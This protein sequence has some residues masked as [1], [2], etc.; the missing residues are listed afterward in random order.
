MQTRSRTKAVVAALVLTTITG[1]ASAKWADQSGSLPGLTSGTTIGL[2]A[3]L[4]GGGV[5]A[6]VYFKKHHHPKAMPVEIP[7][8]ISF[9]ASATDSTLTIKAKDEAVNFA[10][11]SVHGKGFAV[12]GGGPELPLLLK[13]GQP[14]ELKITR[15]PGSSRGEVDL[16][17]L[18]NAGKS[19]ST[20][21]ALQAQK[22]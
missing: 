7:A 6:L 11:M 14:V 22:Q 3:G 10:E 8:K 1:T 2:V 20:A 4:A 19:H 16:T 17:F 21:V 5:A 15:A 18:D 13:P 9:G 12:D